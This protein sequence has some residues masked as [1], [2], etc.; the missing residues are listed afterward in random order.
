MVDTNSGYLAIF[1]NKVSDKVSGTGTLLITAIATYSPDGKNISKYD[2][3][4]LG[5]W[6]METMAP[7]GKLKDLSMYGKNGNMI[8][9]KSISGKMNLARSFNGNDDVVRIVSAN[10][11]FTTNG[12]FSLSVWLKPNTFLSKGG[13]RQEI[14][15]Q[16]HYLVS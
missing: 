2:K 8:G 4:L 11:N 6:D 7:D 14:M 16:G 15:S 9:T 12:N 5:Y 10:L 1:G 3:N 13:W